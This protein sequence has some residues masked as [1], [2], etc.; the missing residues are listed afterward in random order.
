MIPTRPN[1]IVVPIVFLGYAIEL[2]NHFARGKPKA[3]PAQN[4][5]ENARINKFAS[6]VIAL[7][8]NHV[9]GR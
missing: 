5:T 2:E 1:V 4:I 9:L 6:L 8:V 3:A 7:Q